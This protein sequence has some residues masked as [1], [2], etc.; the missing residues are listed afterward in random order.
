M[1][2]DERIVCAAPSCYITS[3]ERLFATIGPQDA[4][5]N[6]TGQVAFGMEHA[7]YLT[8]RA[9]RPTLILCATKDF[10]DIQGTWTSFREAKQ[11]YGI[12]GHPERVDIA[13]NNASHGYPKQQ[14]EAMVNWM[15]RWLLGKD[16]NVTEPEFT[17]YKT[18][19]LQC[20]RTGQV[21]EEFKGKSVVDFNVE[22][23]KELAATRKKKW[24]AMTKDQQRAAV[25]KLLALPEKVPA[26]KK[27]VVGRVTVDGIVIEK[28]VFETEPGILV[29]AREYRPEKIPPEVKTPVHAIYV[30]DSPKDVET[31][32]ELASL[33]ATITCLDVRGFGETAPGALKSDRPTYFGV[34]GNDSFLA[35]HIGRPLLGQRTY[36]LLAILNY[37]QEQKVNSIMLTGIGSGGPIALHAGFLHEVKDGVRLREC[38]V[39]WGAVVRTPVSYNQMTNDLPGALAVYDL[40]D[41]KIEDLKVFD[42]VDA[43]GKPIKDR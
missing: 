19:E 8:M 11:V 6:I 1:A 18:A 3:L 7:D 33:G 21:L 9:P 32:R 31:A 43:T 36:D 35:M 16:G 42:P 29:P 23:E 26:A 15:R 40:P 39:S 17:V 37:L 41:L 28:V 30:S 25:R 22:R 38:L 20:T 4:E 14:R 27:K 12:L 5:Q 34:D 13:E 2:L 24:E 10:F